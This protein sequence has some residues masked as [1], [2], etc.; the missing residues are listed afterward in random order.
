MRPVKRE[1][2]LDFQTYKDGRETTRAQVLQKKADLMRL[3]S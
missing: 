2:L 3:L 1:E